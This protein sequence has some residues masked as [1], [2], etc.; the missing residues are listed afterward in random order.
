MIH[1][2]GL[3]IPRIMFCITKFVKVC[4]LC[5]A[6]LPI[7]AMI[8]YCGC[9]VVVECSPEKL[10]IWVWFPLD[11]DPPHIR[12]NSEY[13]ALLFLFL[14]VILAK[15]TQVNS[16]DRNFHVK[17]MKGFVIDI[18]SDAFLFSFEHT[19]SKFQSR[20]QQAEQKKNCPGDVLLTL[21]VPFL[22][23]KI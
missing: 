18:F 2:S 12:H 15:W 16:C 4:F 8:V 6:T 17:G 23:Q 3:L 10:L 22:R 1:N 13:N 20:K 7:F 5:V 19:L 14:S 21:L 9:G 11:S